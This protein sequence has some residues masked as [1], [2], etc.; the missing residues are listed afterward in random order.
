MLPVINQFTLEVVV[1]GLVVITI[2]NLILAIIGMSS[3]A[4]TK[5]KL[6]RWKSIHA[7]ADLDTVYDN[8]VKQVQTLQDAFRTLEREHA[9]LKKALDSRITTAVIDRYNAF[10]GV[11][12]D[13][14]FSIALLDAHQDGVV[15][16]NIY[17]REE[18]RT[19]AK[20]VRNGTSSY[21]LTEEEQRVIEQAKTQTGGKVLTRA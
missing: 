6:K 21:A 4:S 9:D 19:Y 12:S 14:S 11:G 16:S 17:G 5:R 18:S 10:T 20:P 15:L 1:A 3:A 7:T 8:T 2:L 13:L